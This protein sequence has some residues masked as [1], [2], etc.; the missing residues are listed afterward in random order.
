VFDQYCDDTFETVECQNYGCFTGD[1]YKELSQGR[2][3]LGDIEKYES[4]ARLKEIC[5]KINIKKKITDVL[6]SY[7]PVVN[8][9]TLGVHV[10]TSDMNLVHPEYGNFTTSDYI[11][12]IHEI[13]RIENINNIFVAS[14]N[15]ESIELISKEFKNVVS[16]PCKFREKKEVFYNDHMHVENFHNPLLW[17][18]AFIE[19][20]LLSRCGQLLCRVSNLA[21]ASIL[22]SN[23][24]TK[25]HRL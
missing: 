19:M 15:E 9:K 4:F 1:K 23:T 22:F 5:S 12:K 16:Y 10:R 21:N 25:I 8:G 18:E 14:D 13:I 11:M 2:F 7:S 3:G 17:E 24:L 20:L 6:D